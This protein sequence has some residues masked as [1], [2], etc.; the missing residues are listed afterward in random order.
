MDKNKFLEELDFMANKII[1]DMKR[2]RIK[3]NTKSVNEYV[4]QDSEILYSPIAEVSMEYL[5]D[6]VFEKINENKYKN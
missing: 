5:L 6:L 2:Q 4:N 1:E 3:I